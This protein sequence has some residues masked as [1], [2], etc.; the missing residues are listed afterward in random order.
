[1][2]PRAAVYARFSDD[3]QN[4]RSI[5]DQVALCAAY[6][7]RQGWTVTATFSDAA[8]SGAAKANRPGLISALAA[9]AD[10]QFDLLLAED[11]DRLARNLEDLAHVWNRLEDAGVQLWT[12]GSGRVELMHVALKG[13]GAQ[14]FLRNLSAKTRRGML[15]NAEAGLATGARVYGYR[16]AP[17]GDVQVV[18]A[19]AAV[20]RRIF[21]AYA[22]GESLRAITE[23]LN[24]EGVPS[25]S[26]GRW[27][28]STITGSRQRGNGVLRQ[29]LY[30]GEKVWNR[31]AMSK[32]RQ[33]GR[34]ISRP[35][36][37]AEWK[38]TPVPHLRLVDA[39]TW[40]AVHTRLD[41]AG[42]AAPAH[43]APAPPRP[44]SGLIRCAEC[45]AAMTTF[46]GRGRL[47][48]AARRAHGAAACG[49]D[50]SVA[51]HEVED[52]VLTA[53]RTRLLGPEAVRLYVKTYHDAWA[54]RAQQARRDT[55][56]LYRRAQ[57]LDRQIARLVDAITATGHSPALT[58]RLAQLEQDRADVAAALR[59]ADASSRAATPPLTLHPRLAE[60]FA[61]RVADLQ[62]HLA[63]HQGRAPT[64]ASSSDT[65]ARLR[66]VV[67]RV[68]VRALPDGQTMIRL[69]GALAPALT[70]GP[71]VER[72][73]KVVAGAGYTST[74]PSVPVVFRRRL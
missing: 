5:A 14:D 42:A 25:P 27:A 24:L 13:Y 32:D 49:H 51:R 31:V 12:C 16:S 11:E 15:A 70:D 59:A 30:A 64:S 56:P 52:R 50:R 9:A 62:A 36:P 58:A 55:A 63:T 57:D 48:C 34:R 8:I 61:R 65:L 35:R 37:P 71:V 21:A 19:E 28:P 66:Q 53:L 46:N 33:T 73:N 18:E 22:A 60:I 43:R 68:D 47:I 20:V 29:G 67:A 74:Q 41:A 39:E 6:A 26:G 4:P 2:M 1:M 69:H 10:H 40:A 23:A 44:L 3:V 17:G 7:Q 72:L 38:R 45:G 54:A